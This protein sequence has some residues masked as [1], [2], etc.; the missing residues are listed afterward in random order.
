MA[1]YYILVPP[2]SN[3]VTTGPGARLGP[4]YADF[5]MALLSTKNARLVTQTNAQL[6]QWINASWQEVRV[7]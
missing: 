7:V 6:F 2:H 5:Q 3:P 4:M 1:W